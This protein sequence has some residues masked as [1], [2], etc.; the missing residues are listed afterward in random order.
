MDELGSCR[1][2]QVPERTLRLNH[3]VVVGL[4]VALFLVG[5]WFFLVRPDGID[6][7]ASSSQQFADSFS[8]GLECDATTVNPE[9]F[10]RLVECPNG[11][12]YMWFNRPLPD[13]HAESTMEVHHYKCVVHSGTTVAYIRSSVAMTLPTNELYLLIQ[14]IA[15]SFGGDGTLIGPDCP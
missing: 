5:V 14:D 9:A 15:R 3:S 13:D 6:G 2:R 11:A 12:T 10:F 1:E 7:S 4:V 8:D